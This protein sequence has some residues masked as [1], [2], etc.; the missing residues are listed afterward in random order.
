MKNEHTHTHTDQHTLTQFVS[1][2]VANH[3]H[4]LVLSQRE[5]PEDKQQLLSHHLRLTFI[6]LALPPHQPLFPHLPYLLYL[7]ALLSP[8]SLSPPVSHFISPV[9]VVLIFMSSLL[10]YLH[11][12]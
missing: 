4:I 9:N 11:I 10:P 3:P 1:V 7:S 2:D 12:S 5:E 6:T 8:L